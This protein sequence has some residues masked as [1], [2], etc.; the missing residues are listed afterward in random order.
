[1]ILAASGLGKAKLVT[2]ALTG[3]KTIVVRLNG[4]NMAIPH[5]EL[6]GQI[7]GL[8]LSSVGSIYIYVLGLPTL[9]LYNYMQNLDDRGNDGK[10]S[11]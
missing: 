9:L 4:H 5:D 6:M 7:M 3:P 11:K 8:I 2:A 10:G 1:M